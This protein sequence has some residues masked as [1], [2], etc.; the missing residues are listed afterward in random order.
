MTASPTVGQQV[1]R[2]R[3]MTAWRLEWLRLIRTPRAISLATVYLLFGLLGPVIAKYM[4]DIVA[5]VESGITIT[6]PPPTPKD[7][8]TQYISQVSQT[9]L[10]VVLVVAAGALTFDSRRGIATFLRTRT[11]SMWALV[12]PRYAVTSAAAV[13]AYTL[14]LL[15]AWYETAL[16]IGPLPIPAM[17]AG[18]LCQA[19]FLLFAVAVVAFAASLARGALG[20]IGIALA[21]LLVLP[22]AG[23]V[24]VVHDWLPTTLVNAPVDLL[25][26]VSLGDYL[27]SLAVTVVAIP[28][29]LVAAVERLSRRE[30]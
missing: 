8:I 25:G 2:P 5:H 26:T 16:L 29:L 17:V 21:V 14:G 24:G 6:V 10:I 22:I 19:V 27:P 12:L 3:P 4:A 9:G 20:T 30:V 15:G 11:S 1:H 18:L 28:V 13:A 23:V 7:G